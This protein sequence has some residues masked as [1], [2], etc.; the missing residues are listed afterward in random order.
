MI[1]TCSLSLLLLAACDSF[2][3]DAPSVE[4]YDPALAGGATTLFRA[5]PES[6]TAPAP[7][8]DGAQLELHLVGDFEFDKKFVASP[9]D[10]N[11]GLGP[12]FNRTSCTSCHG[13]NGRNTPAESLL[14]RV[15]SGN[16]FM[17]RPMDV[18]GFGL[19]IQDRAV[20]GT[21]PEA[22]VA[23]EYEELPGSFPDGEP[24]SL[25]RPTYR[26]EN[27]ARPLP[28]GTFISPRM[29]RPVFGLGLLEA[30][31]ESSLEQIAEVQAANGEVTGR[32]N[33]VWDRQSASFQVGRFGWKANEPNLR[34]QTADAYRNDMGVTSPLIMD[35]TSVE[36]GYDDN[37]GD[38]PEISNAILD[39]VT[40]YVQSLAVPAARDVDTYRVERG[41]M[42]F[43]AIGCASCHQ[44][45][46]HTGMHPLLPEVSN[47]TIFPYTDLLLHDMGEGLA[48]D[49][50]DFGATGREWRTPP[51]W[52]IGL[53]ELV[54]QH[55]FLLHDGRARDLT[56][57]IL[58]HG[59]E[60]Q[61]SRDR[62]HVLSPSERSELLAFIE[63]L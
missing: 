40:F 59:G 49:R 22:L 24:Y 28:A 38:D 47:Q 34:Q 31:P 36:S 9:A 43:E 57:A 18:P 48:D 17:G 62:F 32:I 25:R 63:S 58:W 10:I 16:D 35:E 5:T 33:Y 42:L 21:I 12:L 15:S 46:L 37:L 61:L 29:A 44:P 30:V 26:L 52:G 41:R 39:Q 20:P 27:L 3:R 6:F 1:R 53:T 55:T 23:I 11:G 2:T 7:N 13:K 14:L 51:L 60:A 54:N 8:L 4:A 50:D 19:Q 45:R 56:E